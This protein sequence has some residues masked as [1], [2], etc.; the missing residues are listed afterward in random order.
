LIERGWI[1]E[2]AGQGFYKRSGSEILTLDLATRRIDRAKRLVCPRLTARRIDDV[3]ERVKALFLGRDKV[4]AFLRATLGPMLVYTAQ[5]TPA[6]AHSID[7]VDR[8]MRWGFGWDLGPFELWDA[9]GS[10]YVLD[11]VQPPA[12]PPLVASALKAAR[13]KFR[14]L[15]C[16]RRR[17]T[18]R[19]SGC[20]EDR[21]NAAAKPRG[22]PH[23]ILATVLLRSSFTRR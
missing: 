1:S 13:D 18:C 19:F 5:V 22:Q 3:G 14:T 17:Q 21:Q 2:K 20:G 11:A 16:R 15:L 9:I 10:T 6:I 7:D 12:I 4:G 23:P 8:A